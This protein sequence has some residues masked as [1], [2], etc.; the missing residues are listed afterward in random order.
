MTYCLPPHLSA[1][2]TPKEP[3]KY[4]PPLDTPSHLRKRRPYT[5][6][7]VFLSQFETVRNSAPS[8]VTETREEKRTRQ[9]KER[10]DKVSAKLQKDLAQWDPHN[11]PK[12]TEDPFKTLLVSRLSYDTT[13]SKLRRELEAYGSVK[14]VRSIYDLSGKPKGY[15]FVEFEHER[16]M[17]AAYKYA[18]GKKVD[19]RRILVDVERSRTVKNW[20]PRRLGGGLGGTRLG[21]EDINVKHSGREENRMDDS[22]VGGDRKVSPDRGLDRDRNRDRR[23]RDRGDTERYRGRDRD[24]DRERDRDR[25]RDRYRPRYDDPNSGYRG[26]GRDYRDRDRERDRRDRDRDR[27]RDRGRDRRHDRS[28]S[29]ERRDYDRRKDVESGEIVEDI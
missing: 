8:V 3:I 16:D 19:G 24:R 11:N 17:K 5:G 12:G 9:K 15:A 18:D 7:S 13:E 29:R 27:D 1:F 2:F 4:L 26:R 6:V 22:R 14:S 10:L 23:D 20:L 21:G 28:R 25:D